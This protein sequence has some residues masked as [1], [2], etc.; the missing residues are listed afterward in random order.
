[1]ER[2]TLNPNGNSNKCLDVKDGVFTNGT[3]VQIWDCNN[4]GSQRWVV[5][6]GF[7]TV[8]LA[9][10][11]FCLDSS[12]ATPPNGTV[13]KIW[14]CINDIPAQQWSFTAIIM[15]GRI[16]LGNQS[17]CLD[18]NKGDVTNGNVVQTWQCL[19]N[20]NQAWTNGA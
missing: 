9:N 20:S 11:N 18:L 10:T 16:T 4:T 3:P 17:I 19:G 6:L 15:G 2:R 14:Q 12:F 8:R 7:T 5:G 13:A 1:M